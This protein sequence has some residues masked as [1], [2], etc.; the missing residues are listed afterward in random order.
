V[1]PVEVG[2]EF[3]GYR[4]E[5]I[6]G[7]GGMGRVYR[8][9][10]IALDRPVALKV[11]VP[12]LADDAA[13]R[14]RFQRESRLAA[15]ID[16]PN[17]IPVYQADTAEGRLFITM[18]WVQGH[19]LRKI[20]EEERRL[21]P[22][23]AATITAQLA[24]A[25]DAAHRRGLV[26]RDVKPANVMVTRHDE[27]HVYLMDFGLTKRTGSESGVTRTGQFV[28]TPDYI[29]PEQI[30]GEGADA[31][32]DVYALGGLLYHVLT[33]APP[34]P[35]DS[36]IARIYAHLEDDPPEASRQAG[37]IPAAV[38]E[39]IATAMAKEPE[40]R[41]ASAAE[42]GRAARSA[43]TG[44]T[45]A[46]LPSPPPPPPPT[47]ESPLPSTQSGPGSTQAE[48]G[49]TRDE[50]GSTQGD[51]PPTEIE[52]PPT[53]A[54]GPH[55]QADAPSLPTA[56]VQ[57][58]PPAAPATTHKAG[59][60]RPR[61]LALLGLLA[62]AVVAV[63]AVVLLM[64][65]G[66]EP[67]VAA[68]V[69]VEGGPDG[70]AVAGDEVWVTSAKAGTV[71][72]LSASSNRP[73]G[74]PI[75]VGN[76]PDEVAVRDGVAWVTN[77]EDGTVS[78]ILGGDTRDFPV[79]TA[80]EG[81]SLSDRFVW[82]ANGGDDT[83]SRLD[84]KTGE[85]ADG[86]DDV[87]VGDNPIGVFAGSDT[88]WVTNSFSGTVSRLDAGSGREKGRPTRV[89]KNVR[90]V[91][92][93]LGSAWVSSTDENTVTRLNPATGEVVGSPTRVG[94]RPKGMAVLNDQLW[95]ANEGDNTVT[96]LDEDGKVVGSPIRVGRTPVGIAA[97]AGSLWV[98]D[99]ASDT[100]TRIDP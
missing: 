58:P 85:P 9:T 30:R 51:Q 64:G 100:V 29:S 56:E 40:D 45:E 71:T 14:T 54:E 79:G 39:V 94:K 59:A 57:Q 12:E 86:R 80:P 2:S 26:H 50:P 95:V 90:N 92:E 97:G 17:V 34:F 16:H 72:R 32:A 66:S 37:G 18:R 21:L 25:L 99:N 55:T 28:G 7:E 46:P 19:D 27:E 10:Q 52:A 60:R 84:R 87:R 35:R 24:S 70:I 75:K 49:P 62:V 15:S 44:V 41:Y 76:N 83:V 65:G 22:E 36:D 43:L 4:I 23:R 69:P 74:D 88:V 38:D 1:S 61:R 78:R 53:R 11:I 96:R 31:R 82:V 68:T 13:F 20:L 81:L 33:G 48:A 89:G 77:T 98:T 6:A 73:S 42:F 8:A 93:G 5:A 67:K 91:V 3:A 63:I 47:K